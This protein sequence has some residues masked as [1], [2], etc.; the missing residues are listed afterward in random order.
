MF[1]ISEFSKLSRIS[2]KTLRFYDKVGVL[3]P[4]FVNKATGYRYYTADQLLTV[5]RIAAFK[6]QGFT[7]EKIKTLLDEYVSSKVAK[8]TLEAK[9]IELEFTI[10]QARNQIAEIEQRVENLEKITELEQSFS[11]KL[12]SVESQ[13]VASIRDTVPHSHLCLLLDEIRQYV[14]T[15]D[16]KEKQMIVIWHS[17]GKEDLVDIEVAIPIKDEIPGSDRVKVN[18]LPELTSAVSYVHHID[19]YKSS[20]TEI[21]EL[22]KWIENNGYQPSKDPIRE[23]YLTSD[24]DFYGRIR[25]T[26]LL[27]P[28]QT[29]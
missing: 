26:E 1:K 19:P 4:S 2:V 29:A 12:K 16:M 10:E 5:Q 22:S 28:V 21:T 25:L 13:L 18:Y 9:R 17:S 20:N 27:I 15:Y 23:V 6:E 8:E 24:K 3:K 11:V 14:Q 7:L